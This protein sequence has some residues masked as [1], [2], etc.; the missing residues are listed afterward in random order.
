MIA[1]PIPLNPP[2]LKNKYGG[3]HSALTL[4]KHP[5][6]VVIVSDDKSQF[7]LAAVLGGGIPN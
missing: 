3:R 7:A 1:Q 4:A 6:V 5:G 2:I